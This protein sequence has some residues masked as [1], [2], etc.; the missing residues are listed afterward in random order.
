MAL[1]GNTNKE[2]AHHGAKW[3]W[4]DVRFCLHKDF[5]LAQK[6]ASFNFLPGWTKSGHELGMQACVCTASANRQ[7]AKISCKV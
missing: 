3:D 2:T 4:N 5:L 7:T 6:Q 1:V